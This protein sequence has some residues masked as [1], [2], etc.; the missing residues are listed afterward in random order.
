MTRITDGRSLIYTS[1]LYLYLS[2]GV[3]DS[4]RQGV[5]GDVSESEGLRSSVL[6]VTHYGMT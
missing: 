1:C 2:D 3:W 5:Q 4:E 6:D